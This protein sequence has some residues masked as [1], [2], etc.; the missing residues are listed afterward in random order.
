MKINKK[1][2]KNLGNLWKYDDNTI[3]IIK[4]LDKINLII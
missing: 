1:T 4:Y 2:K 3:N